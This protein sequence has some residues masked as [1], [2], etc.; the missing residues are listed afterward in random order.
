[1]YNV[2]VFFGLVFGKVLGLITK[3]EVK[4]GERY[5]LIGERFVLLLLFVSLFFVRIDV[6]SVGILIGLLVYYFLARSTVFFV[7]LGVFLSNFLGVEYGLLIGSLGFLYLLIF[8]R[9]LEW[10]NVLVYFVIFIL[11]FGLFPL[12][13]FIK[14]NLSLF[15]SISAGGIIGPVAQLG[16]TLFRK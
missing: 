10:F 2:L 13:S 14:G 4:N 11:P 5:F 9:E 16:R 1:M 12:E 3:E 15:L 6:F 7:G 8:S